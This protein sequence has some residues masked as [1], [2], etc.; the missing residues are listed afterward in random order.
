[1]RD[2]ND[3]R[4]FAAV[5]SHGGIS[6]ASRALGAPKSRVSRRVAALENDLGVRLFERSTRR[7]RVTDV[8]RDIYQH[9]RAALS[10]ADA[11]DE[12]VTRLKA[13]PQG[14]VRISCPPGAERKLGRNLAEF[15]ADYP[16][17]RLQFVVTN[18]RVDLIEAGIDVAVHWGD[19]VEADAG[20]Q[21][22][23]VAHASQILVA[24]PGLVKQRGLPRHPDALTDFP[25]L[26]SADLAGP[27]R[28][29]LTHADGTAVEVVHQPRMSVGDSVLIRD[30]AIADLGVALL[31][32]IICRDA[33]ASGALVQVLPDWR[34]RDGM[35]YLLFPS[36]RG[37]LPGVRAVIDF[38]AKALRPTHPLFP[39]EEPAHPFQPRNGVSLGARLVAAP[40]TQ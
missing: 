21:V 35:A 3:L 22:R 12:A 37:L 28:W 40:A 1:M 7:F 23:T 24:S 27:A 13:E 8:G 20:L 16:A 17:L 4:L 15:L 25:T 31:S 2:L 18:C 19:E 10:E 11:I 39:L 26:A 9:A 34:S 30:C 38:L 32:E 29:S 5:V 14:L 33:L 6:A 36:R